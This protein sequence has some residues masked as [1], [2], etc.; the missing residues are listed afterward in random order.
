MLIHPE[1]LP[2]HGWKQLKYFSLFYVKCHKLNSR[3]Y[4]RPEKRHRYKT[5]E[6]PHTTFWIIS[7]A[8]LSPASPVPL[9]SPTSKIKSQLC[10]FQRVYFM[11]GVGAVGAQSKP[12]IVNLISSINCC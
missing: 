5:A 6:Y 9:L 12:I 4:V 7:L 2:C 1:G 10:D 3:T 8:I 11:G